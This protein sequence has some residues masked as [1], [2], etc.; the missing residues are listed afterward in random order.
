MTFPY[1]AGVNM[2][3]GSGEFVYDT[4]AYSGRAPGASAFA[5]INTYHAP[6]GART[7]VMFALDQLQAALPNCNTVA[8]VVQ[9]F[10]NSLNAAA[11]QIYPS[12][13]YVQGG[14]IGAFAPT[15]GGSESWRVSDVSLSTPGLIQISRN[16]AGQANYGGTPS[17]QSIVRCL[18]QI[19]SRGLN[20]ALYLLLGLDTPGKPWRAGIGFAPDI[21]SAATAAT[22]SFLGAA[23][24]AMF[25]PDAVNLTVHYAGA[26]TDFTY[27]RFVLHYANLAA[28]AGGVSVFAIGSELSGLELIRGPAWTPTGTTDGAGDAVWDYPFVAGLVTLANDCRAVFDAAGLVKNLAAREN[29]IVYSPDWSQ[30]MGAQH[31]GTGYAGIWPHLDSLYAS[32]NFDY[33]AFDNYMPLAD[34]TTGAGGVDALNWRSAAQ[35]M[36]RRAAGYDRSWPLHYA[37]HPRHR[38]S[39]GEYRRRREVQLLVRGLRVVANARP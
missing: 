19:K 30:W 1:V 35:R 34:W 7:D 9:W 3:P 26:V 17:D 29:L 36:A 28:L 12:S 5:P 18:Q 6:G 31:S 23:T 10:A 21:S 33:V 27:R 11:C 24:P 14:T 16:G 13:T 39:A 22:T 8:V 32:A 25:T 2:I 15:A 38:L 37:R 20:A 4:V